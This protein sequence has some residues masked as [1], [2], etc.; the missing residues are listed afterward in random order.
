MAVLLTILNT[1]KVVRWPQRCRHLQKMA[2]VCATLRH[3]VL[4]HTQLTTILVT[5]MKMVAVAN[6]LVQ[7]TLAVV[8][9]LKRLGRAG[10]VNFTTVQACAHQ[11]GGILLCAAIVSGRSL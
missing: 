1:P 6:A 4:S 2:K 3:T 10:H 7:A 8:R 5:R 9:Q 11:D